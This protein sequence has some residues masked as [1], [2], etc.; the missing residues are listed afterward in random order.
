VTATITTEDNVNEAPTGQYNLGSKPVSSGSA[1]KFLT[2][3]GMKANFGDGAK[4]VEM[5]H[6]TVQALDKNDQPVDWITWNY[7]TTN[8]KIE[9]NVKN[10]ETVDDRTAKLRI[11][12]DNVAEEHVVKQYGRKI[13]NFSVSIFSDANHSTTAS[14][15]LASGVTKYYTG[16]TAQ[17]VD[18][19]NDG[20]DDGEA[21]AWGTTI[22]K[23][24]TLTAGEFTT[25]SGTEFSTKQYVATTENP[26]T[27]TETSSKELKFTY[28]GVTVVNPIAQAA[29]VVSDVI[30]TVGGSTTPTYAASTTT[31]GAIKV[32]AKFK[33]SNNKAA[34][35]ATVNNTN[36][37]AI[38]ADGKYSYSITQSPSWA[39]MDTS[40][41]GRLTM[42]SND[43]GANRTATLKVQYGTGSG[44]PEGEATI[45]QKK[46]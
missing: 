30:V 34:G 6:V 31:T 16:I 7:D 26:G 38:A 40:D 5:S 32:V 29:P 8:D 2:V 4:P 21:K 24:Y 44:A 25:V 22:Y 23:G 27:R 45:T 3:T 28:D 9:V 41:N 46:P 13:T 18:L 37:Q 12:Y 39:N 15:P 1:V 17:Y 20:T 43:T 35:E 42:T 11:I 36:L 19:K 10:N 33:D 14:T